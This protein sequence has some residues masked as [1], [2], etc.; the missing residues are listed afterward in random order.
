MTAQPGGTPAFSLLL[1]VYH[2]DD[3]GFLQHSFESA[4][5]EQTLAPDEVVIVQDGPVGSALAG[6]LDRLVAESQVPVR[7]V[8][9]TENRGLACALEAGLAACRHEI[10]ARTDAD[11]ICAPERFARQI[12]LVADGFDI[13]GSAIREFVT[14]GDRSGVVRV[15][16][17]TPSQINGAARF[18]SPF[19]HPSVAYRKSVVRA[20]GG[21]EDLPLLED[22]WLFAR[23]LAAGARACNIAD[24]L[25]D[26]R[27]GAGAYARR[28]G[29][30]LLRSEYELQ[31]RLRG[32]GFI[33][34]PQMVR[35]IV[36]RCGYRL[37]P[38]S[39]RRRAYRS[40]LADRSGSAGT[41]QRG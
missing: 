21:Y 32:I 24:P 18:H 13:V 9:L 41:G 22:Y 2:A 20:V 28:G 36:I 37:V 29:M 31:R 3:P 1:P 27:V 5:A 26:Y 38:E 7:Q 16:P 33:S 30:R 10:V 19:N 12:P 23:M 34:T 6:M 35:N 25:L 11:D 40:L 39:L 4:T 14:A 17:L 8:V 15:P